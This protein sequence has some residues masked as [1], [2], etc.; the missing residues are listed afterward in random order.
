MPVL[1]S[2]GGFELVASGLTSIRLTTGVVS[3]TIPAVDLTKAFVVATVSNGVSF[4]WPSYPN[5]A[6]SFVTPYMAT[7]RLITSTSLR[8]E[9]GYGYGS[10]LVSPAGVAWYVVEQQ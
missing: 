6:P 7:A 4:N 5:N 10:N 8:V 3:V 1:G 9:A 2:G